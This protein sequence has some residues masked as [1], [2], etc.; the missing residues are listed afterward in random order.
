MQQP[1]DVQGGP[2]LG[3]LDGTIRVS[4]A[5]A[6][7]GTLIVTGTKLSGTLAGQSVSS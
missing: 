3:V 1:L 5:R 2:V 4:G 6:A 7:H